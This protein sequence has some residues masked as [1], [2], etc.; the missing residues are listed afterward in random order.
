MSL[1]AN[2]TSTASFGVIGST[3][4]VPCRWVRLSAPIVISATVPSGRHR[5][6][7]RRRSPSAGPASAAGAAAAPTISQASVSGGVEREAKRIVG[8]LI[9]RKFVEAAHAGAEALAHEP[10]VCGLATVRGRRR[11]PRP[12]RF[13]QMQPP[14]ADPGR[15]PGGLGDPSALARQHPPRGRLGVEHVHPVALRGLDSPPLQPAVEPAP[16]PRPETDGGLGPGDVRVLVRPGAVDAGHRRRQ[17][18]QHPRN[19][20]RIGVGP[21]AHG[22][23]RGLD[24]AVILADRAAAPV[25][26]AA[27]VASTRSRSAAAGVRAARARCRARSRPRSRGRA[28]ARNRPASAATRACSR[29]SRQPPM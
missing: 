15:G 10:T 25:G 26:V 27:L 17:P 1:S 6:A 4:R 22:Q 8:C 2:S 12:G 7:A 14:P 11:A 21:A 13:G 19:G 16:S 9:A 23:D 24:R 18:G 5:T 29:S 20:V 3:R 28:G